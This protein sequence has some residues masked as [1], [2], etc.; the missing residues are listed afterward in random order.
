MGTIRKEI[1]I[2][3]APGDVWAAVRDFGTL[4]TR[5]VRGFVVDARLDGDTR[6]V[7]FAS[8]TVQREPL[9]ACDDELRRLV[10]TVED[11]P[12]RAAHYNASVQVL[13]RGADA[14]TV[15]WVI[16]FLPHSLHE[17]LDA[18]MDLGAEAMKATLEGA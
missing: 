1:A 8:G 10:Y 6:I 13:S 11:S 18:A 3:A 7:T 4:H 12:M 2:S 9:V 17:R 5:L 14:S 16:D 15:E